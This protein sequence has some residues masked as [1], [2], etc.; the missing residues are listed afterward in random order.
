MKVNNNHRT[1]TIRLSN[2][3]NAELEELKK[4]L[5]IPTDNG[6]IRFSSLNTE[7]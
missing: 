5:D 6:V 4:L 2:E 7:T 3:E 1:F